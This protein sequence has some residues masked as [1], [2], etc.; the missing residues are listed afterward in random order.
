MR[1]NT[2]LDDKIA[3][4]IRDYT[5]DWGPYIAAGDSV[6]G[7][8]SAP[9]L[10]YG[11]VDFGSNTV[12]GTFQTLRLLG[13]EIGPAAFRIEIETTGGE[14]LQQDCALSIL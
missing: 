5:V 14:T 13:G 12:T 3:G 10:L 8:P 1:K 9:V 7:E 4:E 11:D 2:I 6:S